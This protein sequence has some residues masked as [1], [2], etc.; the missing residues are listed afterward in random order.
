M[1]NDLF[2]WAFEPGTILGQLRIGE[3]VVA[4]PDHLG[5]V[6]IVSSRCMDAVQM[7]GTHLLLF[8]LDELVLVDGSICV[9]VQLGLGQM[10]ILQLKLSFS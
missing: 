9:V 1:R 3:W 4:I 10:L 6:V 7:R 5:R 2:L 8:V